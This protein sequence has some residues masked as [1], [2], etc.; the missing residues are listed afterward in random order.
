MHSHVRPGLAFASQKLK[1][2]GHLPDDRLLFAGLDT[3][4]DNFPMYSAEFSNQTLFSKWVKVAPAMYCSLIK[5]ALN[6][7]ITIIVRI[8]QVIWLAN[9]ADLKAGKGL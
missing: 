7:P 9:K 4:S 8:V 6:K 1:F 2:T 3:E 5:H